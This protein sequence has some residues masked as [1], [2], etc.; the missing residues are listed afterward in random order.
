M[1]TIAR[2]SSFT[3]LPSGSSAL[4]Y[5]YYHHP[6]SFGPSNYSRSAPSTPSEQIP[7]PAMPILNLSVEAAPPAPSSPPSTP[8]RGCLKSPTKEFTTRPEAA[9]PEVQIISPTSGRHTP[10]SSTRRKP[11]MKLERLPSSAIARIQLAE[12]VEPHA[13][14]GK[15]ATHSAAKGKCKERVL[16]PYVKSDKTGWLSDG[17]E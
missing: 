6:P 15:T 13:Q 14:G 17:E 12:G 16:T 1:H 4:A 7:P 8:A 9:E 10:G 11:N 2:A 5:P 3:S